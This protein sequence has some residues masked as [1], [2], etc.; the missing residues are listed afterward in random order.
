[1]PQ[2]GHGSTYQRVDDVVGV[3]IAVRSGKDQNAELHYL[4]IALEN[5]R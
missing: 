3:V 4:R 1:M 5:G 2:I